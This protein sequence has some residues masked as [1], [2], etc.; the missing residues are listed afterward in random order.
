MVWRP[1]GVI[2]EETV[3]AQI[4]KNKWPWESLVRTKYNLWHLI[5]KYVPEPVKMVRNG[6]KNK[7]NS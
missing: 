2:F 4:K 1:N 5:F 7:T 3:F 6:S